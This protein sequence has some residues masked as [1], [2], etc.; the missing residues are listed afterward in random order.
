VVLEGAYATSAVGL[1]SYRWNQVTSAWRLIAYDSGWR[2]ISA[3]LANGWAGTLQCRLWGESVIYRT[4]LGVNSMS[5]T[6]ATATTALAMSSVDAA[7]RNDASGRRVFVY[8]TVTA[9]IAPAAV[10]SDAI[11]MPAIGANSGYN[12]LP[13]ARFAWGGTLPTSLP[14]TQITAPI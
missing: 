3:L 2:D 9:A 7:F 4:G 14:G 5:G 13:E 11:I 6:S 10:G 12:F 8:N 1:A